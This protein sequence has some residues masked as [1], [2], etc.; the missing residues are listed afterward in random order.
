MIPNII[1]NGPNNFNKSISGLSGIF[2]LEILD[3]LNN[4]SLKYRNK[5]KKKI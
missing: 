1:S 4:K 3:V 2:D 5:L